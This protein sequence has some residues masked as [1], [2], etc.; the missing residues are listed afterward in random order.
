MKWISN[1]Y[2]KLQKFSD[3]NWYPPVVGLLAALDSFLLIV[4]TDGIVISSTLLNPHRWLSFAL[5]TAV[6]ST[7]GAIFLALFVDTY[8]MEMILY[9]FPHIQ[10]TQSWIWTLNFF[11]QYGLLL[12]LF[13]SATPVIQ[14]PAIILAALASTPMIPLFFVMLAGRTFKFLVL[15]WISSHAPKLLSQLWGIKGEMKDVGLK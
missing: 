5:M 10:E 1:W 14:H 13:V 15:T 3:K 2:R 12:V 7:V 4:P 6:G 11:D 9:F 8:G